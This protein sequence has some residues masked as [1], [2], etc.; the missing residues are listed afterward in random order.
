[1]NCIGAWSRASSQ[2]HKGW[3][4]AIKMVHQNHDGSI[5]DALAE[6]NLLEGGRIEDHRVKRVATSSKLSCQHAHVMKNHDG[7]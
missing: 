6:G 1:M 3:V 2:E 4:P 7:A 5:D